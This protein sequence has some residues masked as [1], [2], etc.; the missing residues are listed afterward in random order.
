M[1]TRFNKRNICCY[2]ILVALLI[3]FAGL[4]LAFGSVRLDDS[5]V[6]ERILINIRLPRLIA[7]GI[8]GGMLA[9]SGYL[10]QT[11]F[12]NPIAGP[13]VLGISSGAKL[14]VA[15][16]L[17]TM[18]KINLRLNSYGMVMAAFLG[19][20][21][22][23]GFILVI[24]YRVRNMSMLVVCGVMVGYI[25]SS[26]TEL[27]LNFAED[28]NIVNLHY[29]SLGSFSGINMENVG[30]ICW[31][32]SV[33]AIPV[34][35]LTKPMSAYLFGEEYAVNMGV[36]VKLFRIALIV[37]SSVLS[38]TVTAFAGPISFV[39]I[40]VPQL[41]KSLFGTAKPVVIIPACFLGGGVF[42]LFSD[43]LAR[44]IFAPTELSI[45]TV[46]SILGAPVVIWVMIKR[47]REV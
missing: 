18:L 46:T 11:F 40:A 22:S 41:I 4:N 9:V 38:A 47:R 23:T 28:S 45:S 1:K 24:S 25:C 39:G 44:V 29:W 37:F 5:E 43:F 8:L 10:L 36:N 32:A 2:I 21:V 7:A 33:M 30:I 20:L 6:A 27:F 34:M 42:C 15:T 3:V 12:A 16:A 26:V 35:L 17:I 13:Y 14:F 19:S 31:I